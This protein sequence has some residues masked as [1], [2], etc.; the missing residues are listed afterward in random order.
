[1]ERKEATTRRSTRGDS[2]REQKSATTRRRQVSA[3]EE[4]KVRKAA[5]TARKELDTLEGAAGDATPT[6]AFAKKAIDELERIP[7][8][9]GGGG[10]GGFEEEELLQG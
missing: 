10:G 9:A 6:G 8:L 7:P 2:V 4:K 1:M 3:D 5:M